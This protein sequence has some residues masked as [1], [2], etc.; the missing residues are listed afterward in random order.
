MTDHESADRKRYLSSIKTH[1]AVG[2]QQS[3]QHLPLETYRTRL[4]QLSSVQQWDG[5]VDDSV[6]FS[7]G[8]GSSGPSFTSRTYHTFSS[9]ASSLL[10]K[11]ILY[12]SPTYSSLPYSPNMVKH[13]MY[14]ST[15][16]AIS[17][18]GIDPHS[19]LSQTFERIIRKAYFSTA[20]DAS[21]KPNQDNNPLSQ[22]QPVKTAEYTTIAS[23][24][25]SSKSANK[26]IP[27][28]V[29]A[30][31]TAATKTIINFILK[32]PGWTY[33]YLTHPKETRES[34]TAL[35]EM[36]KHEAEHYWVGSKLLYADVQTAMK[37][38][39]RTLQGSS[40]T[41]RERKQLLRTTSDLFRL[42]PFSMFVL[43]P[44][45]EFA[46]PLALRLFPNMLPSTFQDS[47]KEEENM[48]RELQSR[49]AMAQFFQE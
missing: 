6:L 37:L 45:M 7:S 13:V 10:G 17:S 22:K 47:L 44:F 38:V 21:K 35:W 2:D 18:A 27:K 26:S 41:R 9:P 43:I 19:R 46:L 4:Q 31:I 1:I 11:E 16:R 8:V 40:L 23:S 30:A 32:L 39:R 3:Q 24:E 42:V 36:V 33:F 5:C 29:Q 48:K 25:P 14:S 12:K 34:L 28:Q 20:S 49:I 15:L